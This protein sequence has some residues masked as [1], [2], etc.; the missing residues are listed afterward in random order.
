MSQ[1]EINQ[2]KL[3]AINS[4]PTEC[5]EIGKKFFECLEYRSHDAQNLNIA[6]NQYDQFMTETG[7]PRCL[8]ENNLEACL[9]QYQKN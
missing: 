7:V 3:D 2:A 5:Q 6:E 8:A 1:K 4:L 9:I